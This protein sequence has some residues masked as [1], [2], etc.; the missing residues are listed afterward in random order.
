MNGALA[1]V[2]ARTTSAPIDLLKIRFQLQASS[3]QYNSI[4]GAVRSVIREEGPL[5]FWKGNM[6]GIWLYATYSAV[7]FGI[8][9]KLKGKLGHVSDASDY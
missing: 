5:G 7:Q 2:A 1:G 8:Y 9:E 4:L 6:A 3:N